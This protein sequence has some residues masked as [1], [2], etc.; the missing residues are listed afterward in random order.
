MG[1]RGCVPPD[2]RFDATPHGR[3]AGASPGPGES[4]AEPV[5]EAN[6]LHRYEEDQPMAKDIWSAFGVDDDAVADWLAPYGGADSPPDIS[7][8]MSSREAGKRRLV[9]AVRLLGRRAGLI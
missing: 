2:G 6:G 5:T 8:R 4:F 1:H 9:N 3:S 7:R